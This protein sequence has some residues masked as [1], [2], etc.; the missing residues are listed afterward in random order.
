ML[1]SDRRLADHFGGKVSRMDGR[2]GMK[3]MSR[4]DRCIWVTTSCATCFPS[5]VK[6]ERSA[7]WCPRLLP[8]CQ[9]R[10]RGVS[11][12]S[13]GLHV[14]NGTG[15]VREGTSGR[16]LGDTS[17][18]PCVVRCAL[19]ANVLQRSTEGSR[20]VEISRTR[21]AVL[22]AGAWNGRGRATCVDPEGKPDYLIIIL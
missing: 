1:D 10:G 3:V 5:F 14:T 16:R 15:S 13:T 12:G 2:H 20:S 7:R 19:T 21:E 18:W 6:I 22:S 8:A 17:E 11:V 4:V 9:G